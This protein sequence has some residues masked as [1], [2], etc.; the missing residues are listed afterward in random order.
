MMLPP[1]PDYFFTFAFDAMDVRRPC[2]GDLKMTEQV[3]AALIA[4]LCIPAYVSKWGTVFSN[5]GLP[6]K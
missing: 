5:V 6:C 4:L 1:L 2:Y 3:N